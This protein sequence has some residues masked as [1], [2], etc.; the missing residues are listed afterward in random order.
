MNPVMMK[1]MK[2]FIFDP[3]WDELVTEELKSRLKNA[4]IETIITKE[5]APLTDCRAL[6]EGDEERLLW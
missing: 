2:A 6:Y 4:G 5:I 1:S 3:L